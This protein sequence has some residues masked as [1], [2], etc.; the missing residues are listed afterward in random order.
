[1]PGEALSGPQAHEELANRLLERVFLESKPPH[2]KKLFNYFRSQGISDIQSQPADRLEELFLP[3][4]YQQLKQALYRESRAEN[5]EK[6]SIQKTIEN[7]LRGAEFSKVP[8]HLDAICLTKSLDQLR[9]T[10]YPI[11][12]HLIDGLAYESVL[13]T[14]K[15]TDLCREFFHRLE[16]FDDHQKFVKRRELV[17][18]LVNAVERHI[19]DSILGSGYSGTPETVRQRQAIEEAAY[20]AME[21]IR[22]TEI[23]VLLEKGTVN[24]SEA[25]CLVAAC[26]TFL[27][28]R[29]DGGA[30]ASYATYF[31][32]SF[33]SK[34]HDLY[35]RTYKYRFLRLIE[36]AEQY[37]VEELDALL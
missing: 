30:M 15:T 5:P 7:I 3:F 29:S 4:F 16:E 13:A 11:T 28:D 25:A 1:M 35:E 9:P 31:R 6:S 21:R 23:A 2:F 8:G 10:A 36:L 37:Y 14:T 17:F 19:H 20:R 34:F 26:T 33:P 27:A 12:R 32:E 18:A 24:Q 22:T